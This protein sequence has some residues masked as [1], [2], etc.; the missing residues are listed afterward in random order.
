MNDTLNLTCRSTN[1]A[2][3]AE[4]G[5]TQ[6]KDFLQ[7]Q[8]KI[9]KADIKYQ[10]KTSY[11]SL[12]ALLKE[13]EGKTLSNDYGLKIIKTPGEDFGFDVKRLKMAKTILGKDVK[14]AYPNEPVTLDGFNLRLEM[15][16]YLF[17]NFLSF[18]IFSSKYINNS[19][20]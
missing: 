12:D 14:F 5:G 8:I 9:I 6:L 11:S 7:G 19:Q 18:S 17:F 16:I 13:Q 10:K 15:F 1:N 2:G 4:K 20:S 3:V